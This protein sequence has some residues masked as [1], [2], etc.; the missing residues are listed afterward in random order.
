MEY[1]FPEECTTAHV[2]YVWG[3]PKH[4]LTKIPKEPCTHPPKTSKERPIKEY[5]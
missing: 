3:Y 2:S 4:T 5:D 1:G